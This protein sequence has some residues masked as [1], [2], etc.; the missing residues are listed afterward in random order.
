LDFSYS[1]PITARNSKHP[2]EYSRVSYVSRDIHYTSHCYSTV[3]TTFRCYFPAP[4]SR[5]S[6]KKFYLSSG[7]TEQ[8]GLCLTVLAIKRH[9]L[10]T[11]LHYSVHSRIIAKS[12]QL[13]QIRSELV[14]HL[15]SQL[16]SQHRR[17]NI[18]TQKLIYTPQ[19]KVKHRKR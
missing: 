18:K 15:V 16:V 10:L 2:A 3:S 12:Q 19:N 1:K 6:L 14:S 13:E 9:L 8:C 5:Q 7:T 11:Y 4:D 17:R